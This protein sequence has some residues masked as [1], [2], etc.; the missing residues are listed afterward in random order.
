MVYNSFNMLMNTI[1]LYLVA[2]FCKDVHKGYS[3]IVFLYV[4]V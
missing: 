2:D 3:S 4:F 1:C